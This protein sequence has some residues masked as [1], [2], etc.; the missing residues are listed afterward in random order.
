MSAG[1][2][3]SDV[4]RLAMDP[5][6]SLALLDK[7]D[8][9]DK[10]IEY[11]S[12]AW[13][14][15]EPKT[16]FVR[17]W[18]MDAIAD[19]LQAVSEGH[20][21][22][23][24]MNVPPG[25]SKSM[26]SS[27]FWPS[28]E[29]GPKNMP[30]L[31]YVCASYS[32]HL[33]IRDNVRCRMVIGDPW[34]QQKWGD[35]FSIDG[36]NDAKVKFA[37]SV[38]GWKFATSVGGVGAGERGDRVIIDDPHNTKDG[39]SDAK[40]DNVLF[41]FTEVMPTR[42]NDPKKAIFVV[43]MQRVHELDVSGLIIAKELG[44]EHLCIPMHY[45]PRH[46]FG[47]KATSIGWVD[48]RKKL[49]ALAFEERFDKASVHELEKTMMSKGGSYA[50]AGQLEQRPEPR[51][52]GMAKEIWYEFVEPGDVPEYGLD[53]ARGWDFAGTE[54]DGDGSASV[55][56]A[57][58]IST[59]ELYVLDAWW[60]QVSPGG[61][62][63]HIAATLEADGFHV[64][65]SFPQDPG[66][67]GKYQVDDFLDL[68]AG[69]DFEF[70]AETGDKVMRFRPWAAQ[71]ETRAKVG[72]RVKIVKGEWNAMYMDQITKFPRGRFKDMPDGQSRSY[73]A[74][75]RRGSGGMVIPGASTCVEA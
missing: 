29:W 44:F 21:K 20:I 47:G 8:C 38:K 73:G 13:H 64:Y 32:E 34:Y 56:T 7:A 69:Y 36:E 55:L 10:F 62:R 54:D 59:G 71:L 18:S 65:Q 15:I 1:L 11:V 2:D 58:E 45:D 57:S 60:G 17:G 72:R 42:V 24:L 46:P 5:T 63:A 9:E 30:N 39:E 35:R 4:K 14:T 66:Q 28:W 53:R 61:L 6:G 26:M 37:N 40:R 49:D 51:G 50:V 68:L 33:T 74:L 43:I 52:G 12:Q 16:P 70:T 3:I 25:F 67:A 22:K 41:W 31:R 23:L 75:V 48:P 19:H 27:V